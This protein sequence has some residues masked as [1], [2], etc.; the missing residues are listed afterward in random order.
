MAADDLV[1]LVH[2][3]REGL[4][5][6]EEIADA[7]RTV[8]RDDLLTALGGEY[9]HSIAEDCEYGHTHATEDWYFFPSLEDE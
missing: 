5:S 6:D 8:R 1:R 9:H 3:I 2:D 7:L 4:E